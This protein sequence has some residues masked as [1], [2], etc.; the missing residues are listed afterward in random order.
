MKINTFINL[1]LLTLFCH[2]F[3]SYKINH[4]S[5]YYDCRF[6]EFLS[7]CVFNSIFSLMNKFSIYLFWSLKSC[8]W[9]TELKI[10][11]RLEIILCKGTFTGRIRTQSAASQVTVGIAF[12]DWHRW[13]WV[14]GTK[15]KMRRFPQKYK[16]VVTFINMKS[17]RWKT[18]L[19]TV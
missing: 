18:E 2:V 9:E 6:F 3:F 14:A 4:N 7:A 15:R 13:C 16:I 17:V 1:L 11:Y 8:L 19:Q 10:I 5:R 12:L